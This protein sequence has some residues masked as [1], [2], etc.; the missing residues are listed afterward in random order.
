[1]TLLLRYNA[2]TITGDSDGNTALHR[3]TVS[4]H[5]D[6]ARKLVDHDPRLPAIRNGKN[7]SPWDLV[8]A[9][10]RGEFEDICGGAKSSQ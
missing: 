5:A 7:A 8:S 10:H 6:I 9:E 2:N 1:M 4:G 3:A